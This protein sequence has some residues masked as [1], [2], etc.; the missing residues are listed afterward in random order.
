MYESVAN[1]EPEPLGP[2]EASSEEERYLRAILDCP[3]FKKAP[4][5]R[6]LLLYLWQHRG[7]S[8]SEYAIATEALGRRPEFDP[9]SDATVRVHIARLRQKLKEFYETEGTT[10][11][12]VILIPRGGHSLEVQF[13]PS[14]LSEE[15]PVTE[16]PAA[17]PAPPSR[18]ARLPVIGIVILMAV[19]TFQF[20]QNRRLTAALKQ[21]TLPVQRFWRTFIAN[22]KPIRLYLTA[23]VFF[24]WTSTDLK[25]RDPKVNDFAHLEFSPELKAY[26]AKWGRPQLM[27]NYTVAA[28]ALSSLKLSQYLQARGIILAFGGTGEMSAE[29]L[30]DNNVIVLGTPLVAGKYV[31][32]LQENSNFRYSAEG[33]ADGLRRPIENRWPRP[34]EPSQFTT[35]T[36]SNVRKTSYGL[37]EMLPDKGGGSGRILSLTG[38][39]TLPLVSFL[40]LPASLEL[41]ERAWKKEG[42]PKYFEVVVGAEMDGNTV[43]RTWPEAF[44][45]ISSKP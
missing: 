22:G 30:L 31:S 29:T 38:R 3:S 34:G 18:A 8:I 35:Q 4:A 45:P 42:S 1:K 40:S 20:V 9:K 44:R 23:P 39:P 21:E 6:T 25:L 12:L 16:P 13:H 32:Q 28:D 11:P 5:V 15:P 41:L 10:C 24:E 27:Q 43:L 33:A 19:C 37:I 17:V 2:N 7:E 26:A 36:Q 14:A